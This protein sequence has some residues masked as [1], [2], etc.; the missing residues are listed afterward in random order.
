MHLHPTTS[1]PSD[2]PLPH[3]PLHAGDGSNRHHRYEVGFYAP[4]MAWR[5]AGVAD[6]GGA[7]TQIMLLSRA[8]AERGF[9]VCVVAF[10][11][12]G[13]KVPVSAHGVDV[14]LR[15]AYFAGGNLAGRLREAAA[16]RSTVRRID[17]GIVVTRCAGF[18]VG[19]VGLWTKLSGRR[20]VYSSASLLDFDD[21]HGLEKWRDRF[22]F[23]LGVRL[24]DQIVVQ[25]EEQVRLCEQRFGKVPIL[26]RSV[27]EPA[28]PSEQAGEAFLWTGRIEPNKRPLEFVELAR[29]LPQAQFWMIA[30]KPRKPEDLRLWAAIERSAQELPNFDLMSPR[31]RPEL[32]ELL[33]RAVAVVSTSQ[34]EG[35]PNVFLEGWS[36]GIPAL[37]L[38]HD[39]DGVIGQYGLGECARGRRDLFV[40][41][42]RN[43]WDSRTVGGE[44]S[45][46][47]RAYV[48]SKH[49]PDTASREWARALGLS[50]PAPVA[51]SLIGTD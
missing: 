37:A 39:P 1:D 49:S 32:L 3:R 44:L 7:E 6:T 29:S 10:D 28:A 21:D 47:C 31:R 23:R 16:V 35:M 27:S 41:L 5:L 50:K 45:T 24:A 9:A 15:P 40:E 8:L 14:V 11:V 18:W 34:L 30:P 2:V 22:L 26:I 48:Q 4:S 19:L 43:L 13:I 12:P 36:R 17:A 51:A 38:S 42:A 33:G 25:T 20:F 46:R